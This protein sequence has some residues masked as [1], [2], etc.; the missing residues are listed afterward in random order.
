MYKLFRNRKIFS[1]LLQK[2]FL[3]SLYFWLFSVVLLFCKKYTFSRI[4]EFMSSFVHKQ[5]PFHHLEFGASEHL[6][7]NKWRVLNRELTRIP[8]VC[9]STFDCKMIYS[10]CNSDEHQ[11]VKKGPP[12]FFSNA[13][14]KLTKLF[15]CNIGEGMFL[16]TIQFCF[17]IFTPKR[18]FHCIPFWDSIPF[19]I[20]GFYLFH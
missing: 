3:F 19:Y 5:I 7:R 11:N 15:V 17:T 1:F 6:I 14:L 18:A 4:F 12:P 13:S 16:A 9:F 2:I 8:S 20:F 10:L